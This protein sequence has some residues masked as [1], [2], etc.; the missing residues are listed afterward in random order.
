MQSNQDV[1]LQLSVVRK[2]LDR[3]VE[4]IVPNAFVV[5]FKVSELAELIKCI[6]FIARN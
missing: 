4:S 6:Y 5:S 2:M 1:Q 3:L